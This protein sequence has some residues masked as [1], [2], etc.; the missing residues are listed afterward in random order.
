MSEMSA[1]SM[2]SADQAAFAA[3]IAAQPVWDRI[4]TGADAF[5]LP[6]NILLHAGPAFASVEMIS[7][8]VL[9]SACVAAVYEGIATDFE[10]AEMMIRAGDIELEPAQD[11]A[12][13]T[14]LAAVV[15]ASMP[16]HRVVDANNSENVIYSPIN[17]GGRPA[18]RLGLRSQAV[19]DHIR[20]LNSDFRDLLV[21][22]LTTPVDL[23]SI[24]RESLHNGDDC[25]GR[26]PHATRVLMAALEQG[27]DGGIQDANMRDFIDSSPSLFLN[28]WM[29]ASKCIMMSASAIPGS[30]LVTAAGGNGVDSG[31]QISALPGRW[32][33][34]AASPPNGRFDVDLPPQRALP[35]IGDSA[36]VEG[37]GLGAMAINLAPEQL[38]GLGEFLPADYAERSARLLAGPHPQLAGLDCRVGLL[39][40]AAR[41]Y[42]QGPVIG[43]G[44]LDIEGE[45]GRIGG[46]IYDMP[47]TVFSEAMAALETTG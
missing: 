40:R 47:A 33:S 29:A 26:T 19:L 31:I 7:K 12:T 24:A 10:Q 28:L 32:F 45:K 41:E 22:A 27:I 30:S 44:M 14:P 37:L 6:E 17:G 2:H 9:N 23:L 18:M 11:H 39:A 38:K 4:E 13:V 3:A 46:G 20:W 42:Q 1:A 16:L 5:G 35:V 25:H 15:S 21:S 8:P 34:A 36:V 43:L